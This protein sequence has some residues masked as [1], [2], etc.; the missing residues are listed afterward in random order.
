VKWP[1]LSCGCLAVLL[2][3]Q[4]HPAAAQPLGY[5]FAP[6][7]GYDDKNG[8][9]YGAAAFAYREGNDG[10]NLGLY[11]AGNFKDFGGSGNF[12]STTLNLEMRQAEGWIENLHV[13][14]E[15]SFDYY[16]GEGGATSP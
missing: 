2:C 14:L 7:L 1:W 10:L 11:G 4:I 3:L 9:V 16:Y 8:W 5:S 6:I 12:S 15:R 13:L